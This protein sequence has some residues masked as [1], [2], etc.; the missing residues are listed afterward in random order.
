MIRAL[1]SRALGVV[2]AGLALAG[3]GACSRPF[4]SPILPPPH[5]D[6]IAAAYDATWRALIRALAFENVSLRAVAK[7]SGVVSSDEMV[8]PIGVFADCGRIGDD[9]IE[10]DAVVSFTVFVQPNGSGA[11]DVQVNSKMRTQAWRRG[12]SG[13][14]KSETVYVCASTGRWEANLMDSIRRLV[15]D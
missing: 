15:K 2:A 7:D 11:T 3:L 5:R 12:D 13:K 10:G 14:L 1:R 9:V 4:V 8:S 6:Q